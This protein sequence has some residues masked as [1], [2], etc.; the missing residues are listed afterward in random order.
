MVCTMQWFRYQ[1]SRTYLRSATM[2]GGPEKGSH[3]RSHREWDGVPES[4]KLTT[5]SVVTTLH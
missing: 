2:K 4:W 1:K 5:A 3:S